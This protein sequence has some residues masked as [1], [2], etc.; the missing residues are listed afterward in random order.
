MG[1]LSALGLSGKSRQPTHGSRLPAD[2]ERLVDALMNN[3]GVSLDFGSTIAIQIDRRTQFAACAYGAID[4]LCQAH[5]LQ[6]SEEEW[7]HITTV[8]LAKYFFLFKTIELPP[9]HAGEAM[10]RIA[11]AGEAIQARKLGAES[12]RA[13]V[14]QGNPNP[15]VVIREYV[16]AVGNPSLQQPP[17][18]DEVVQE[19]KLPFV[20]PERHEQVQALIAQ[21]ESNRTSNAIGQLSEESRQRTLQKMEEIV[22]AALGQRLPRSMSDRQ[23]FLERIAAEICRSAM[24]TL[25]RCVLSSVGNL[26]IDCGIRKGRPITQAIPQEELQ[27][28]G[29]LLARYQ[30]YAS[31]EA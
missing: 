15:W 14:S 13:L 22:T 1:L 27:Q 10:G 30:R 29:P 3:A 26:L 20:A 6:I 21:F 12:A 9:E 4:W 18:A 28:L 19:V 7:L 16:E 25:D 31:G 5:A 23:D 17:R 24:T 2:I 11:F 8:A